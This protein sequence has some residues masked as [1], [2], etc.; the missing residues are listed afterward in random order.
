MPSKH[1]IETDSW[2]NLLDLDAIADPADKL[3]ECEYFLELATLESDKEKFRW[4]ISAFFGA[5]YSFFE[6][7]ALRAHHSFHNPETGVPIENDEALKTL[8][9]YVRVEQDPKRSTYV[10]TA[11]QHKITKVLYDLRGGNTHHFPLS[12]MTS[13]ERLPDDFHFGNISGK[14]VPAL[15]FCREVMSLIHLVESELRKHY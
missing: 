6:I 2:L 7:H 15:S 11:G 10:K 4:L 1:S 5:A 12:L 9:R 8:R 3:S 14:G 13:G